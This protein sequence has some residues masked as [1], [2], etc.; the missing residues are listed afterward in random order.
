M[1]KVGVPG[2]A[3]ALRVCEVE[4]VQR[5][6]EGGERGGGVEKGEGC[7]GR[8]GG[9]AVRGVEVRVGGGGELVEWAGGVA[10]GCVAGDG[11]G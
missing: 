7:V 1:H 3:Q 11:G 8:D 10:L 2:G 6:V 4:G 5:G 9:E